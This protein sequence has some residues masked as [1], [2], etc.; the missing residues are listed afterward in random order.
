ML[1]VAPRMKIVQT[2]ERSKVSK[3]PRYR[4]LLHNDDFNEDKYV[5]KIL[6]KV[7][8]DMTKEEAK[9]K[10]FEAHVQG[11]SL[12]R[13]YPQEMAESYCESIRLHGVHTSVESCS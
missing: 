1:T 6:H 5:L 13:V 2:G 9:D 10:M 12:L 4:L 11:I 7:I 8:D 3:A